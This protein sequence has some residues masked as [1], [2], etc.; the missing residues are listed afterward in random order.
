M[1]LAAMMSARSAFANRV[2]LVAANWTATFTG[3]VYITASTRGGS[4]G[5]NTNGFGTGQGG[6]GGGCYVTGYPINVTSGDVLS[7]ESGGSSGDN[8][9][10]VIKINGGI[11][12]ILIQA[13]GDASFWNDGRGGAG[14]GF[15]SIITGNLTGGSRGNSAGVSGGDGTTYSSGTVRVVTGGGGGAGNTISPPL[16][17]GNGGAAGSFAAIASVGI[18]G[19][20]GNGFN[21]GGM[22]LTASTFTGT[23]SNAAWVEW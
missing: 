18:W 21:P 1:S 22:R 10:F 11:Q 9:Q 13:G 17:G 19:A 4:D 6:G 5:G 16:S 2:D 7:W 8:V 3:T 23:G 14:G 12:E 15:S 20:A